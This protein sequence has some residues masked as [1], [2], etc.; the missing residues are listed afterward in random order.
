MKKALTIFIANFLVLSFQGLSELQAQVSSSSRSSSR[1]AERSSGI[2]RAYGDGE[3]LYS[4]WTHQD[5]GSSQL[6]LSKMFDSES[7]SKDGSFTVE[8][9]YNMLKISIEGG[10]KEGT[11][12]ISLYKPDGE[13]FKELEIDSS[14]DLRWAKVFGEYKEEYVG[15][16]TYEIT[17]EDCVG[18][19]SL[20]I[21]TH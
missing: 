5:E 6:I 12:E 11:I 10:V 13:S 18:H 19:Y 14:A 3:Y 8:E 20:S 1:S 17:A 15:E 9:H 16:W 21:T 4:A 2:T 7:V